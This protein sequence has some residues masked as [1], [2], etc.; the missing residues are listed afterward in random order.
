MTI[1]IDRKGRIKLP[2]ELL[3]SLCLSENDEVEA[4]VINGNQII[5]KKSKPVCCLCGGPEKF[6]VRI[7]YKGIC[8][9]CRDL[10]INSE[11]GDV[12]YM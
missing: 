10:I 4:S 3:G 2:E 9:R 8:I 12:I 6:Y 11:F 7:G 5:L 1:R